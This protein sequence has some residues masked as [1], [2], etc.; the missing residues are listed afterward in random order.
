MPSSQPSSQPTSK[1]SGQPSA[2]PTQ[3]TGQPSS[4]PTGEPTSK[5]SAYEYPTSRPSF[6]G[7]TAAPTLSLVVVR[8]S[9]VVDGIS[10][11][12][13]NDDLKVALRKAIANVLDVWW[14]YVTE[15]LIESTP[16][17][18]RLGTGASYDRTDPPEQVISG[19]KSQYESA[20]KDI[21]VASVHDNRWRELL[22]VRS[23]RERG[24]DDDWTRPFVYRRLIDGIT[25]TTEI[26][27]NKQRFSDVYANDIHTTM[28]ESIDDGELK[29]AFETQAVAIDTSY[30]TIVAAAGFDSSS[31]TASDVSP[32]AA[33]STGPIIYN[34]LLSDNVTYGLLGAVVVFFGFGRL[35]V[36][37]LWL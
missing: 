10:E 6:K 9:F 31:L 27:S 20:S 35:D 36:A 15:P 4:Q 21:L 23:L 29:Q 5:P 12:D 32:T 22:G 37:P 1:P 18:R 2:Q 34:G 3:P 28:I 19:H 26:S 11:V 14:E 8:V 30:G 24:K 25:V 17:Q 13:M 16:S 7:A 33:P